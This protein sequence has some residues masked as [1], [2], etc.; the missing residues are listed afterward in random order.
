MK[1]STYEIAQ[2]NSLY[3][4]ETTKEYFKGS[5]SALPTEEGVTLPNIRAESAHIGSSRKKKPINFA[6]INDN[7]RRQLNKAFMTFNP[8]IHLANLN[9]LKKENSEVKQ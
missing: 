5:N 9:M 3:L 4:K 7:Y 1:D 2:L 6:Y 8:F